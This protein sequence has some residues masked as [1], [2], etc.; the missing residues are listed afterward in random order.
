M[1]GLRAFILALAMTFAT[2][3]PAFADRGGAL[4]I[5]GMLLIA[6][7]A[8][9]SNPALIAWGQGFTV[10]GGSEGGSAARDQARARR[11]E[12][13]EPEDDSARLRAVS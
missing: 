5:V 7:G 6:A 4:R 3:T 11:R 10:A 1:S 13:E 9:T 8:V 12:D 2:A